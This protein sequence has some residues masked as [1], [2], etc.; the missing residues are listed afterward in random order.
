MKPDSLKLTTSRFSFG[1]SWC[2]P[3]AAETGGGKEH[4]PPAFRVSCTQYKMPPQF[5]IITILFF[6]AVLK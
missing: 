2:E 6:V 3:W 1:Q 4:V 5:L